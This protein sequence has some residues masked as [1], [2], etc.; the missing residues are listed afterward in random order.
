MTTKSYVPTDLQ[1]LIASAVEEKLDLRFK[2]MFGGIMA[3]IEDRPFCSL[4]DVGIA[5][6]LGPPERGELLDEPDARPLQYS[7]TDPPSKLY[8][9]VPPLFHGN[10]GQLRRWLLLS[11]KF[12]LGQPAKAKRKK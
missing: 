1:A 8:V 9:L 4:S 5:I 2:P 10:P 3:Y 7:P 6:K 11:A 12:V